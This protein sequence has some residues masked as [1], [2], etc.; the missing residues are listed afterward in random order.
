MPYTHPLTPVASFPPRTPT[1]PAHKKK[2]C[3]SDPSGLDIGDNDYRP[4]S[5][6]PSRVFSVPR[7][8]IHGG[9]SRHVPNLYL[10]GP[11]IIHR[12]LRPRRRILRIPRPIPPTVLQRYIGIGRGRR[13]R[14]RPRP[15]AVGLDTG[16]GWPRRLTSYTSQPTIST[17]T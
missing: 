3:A 17:T 16:G 11:A 6:M 7:P 12:S 10:H 13:N 1:S 4:I 14:R 9:S 2:G 8:S 15:I 5:T